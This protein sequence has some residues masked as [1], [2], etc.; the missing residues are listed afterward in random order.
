MKDKI[1]NNIEDLLKDKFSEVEVKGPSRWEE[2]ASKLQET[3]PEKKT[4]VISMF[5][6]NSYLVAASIA[7][8][9]LVGLILFYYSQEK[10]I[11]DVKV[12][13]K[14]KDAQEKVIEITKKEINSDKKENI[15]SPLNSGIETTKN[16]AK[17]SDGDKSLQAENV[18]EKGPTEIEKENN[19]IVYETKGEKSVVVLP[20]SSKIYLNRHTV[21]SYNKNFNEQ[22]R[23]VNLSGEA[24]FDVKKVDGKTFTIISNRSKTIVLGTSFNLRSISSETIDEV[25]VVTGKVK[26]SPKEKGGEH[27]SIFLTPGL[28]GIVENDFVKKEQIKDPNFMAWKNE[29]LIFNKSRMDNVI[30]TLEHYFQ[31]KIVVKNEDILQCTFTGSY[32]KPNLE[33]ILKVIEFSL[34]GSFEKKN[35]HEL[36]FEGKGCN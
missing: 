1:K 29:K 34:K 15:N 19:L 25:D 11:G 13:N 36:I 33:E 16:I 3:E 2:I 27:E 22:E 9:L 12:A 18:K 20:D 4:K 7:G 8:I 32:S 26:F 24:F 14:S 31:K 6:I 5:N 28:K 30:A 21:I 23:L 35:E 10:S 17:T